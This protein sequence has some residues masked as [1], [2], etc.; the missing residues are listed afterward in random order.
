MEPL[1]HTAAGT[2]RVGFV[3]KGYPRLSESFILR[4]ILL[5]ERLGLDLHIFALRDPGERTVH[6]RVAQVRA[7]F[8]SIPA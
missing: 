8:R 3:L 1:Q 2:R 7:R 6:E 5:L 4:E